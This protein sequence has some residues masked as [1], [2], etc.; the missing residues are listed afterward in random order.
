MEINRRRCRL[1]LLQKEMGSK[2]N[3]MG[4]PI[5]GSIKAL[6]NEEGR[7]NIVLERARDYLIAEK[8]FD[9]D[10]QA[11]GDALEG[12]ESSVFP[13]SDEGIKVAFAHTD[14]KSQLFGRF[15]FLLQQLVYSGC[16]FCMYSDHA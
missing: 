3:D 1:L 16:Y 15:V 7:D 4:L 8:V 6:K 10:F 9:L 11:G 5:M 13:P 14:F 2:R 12:F